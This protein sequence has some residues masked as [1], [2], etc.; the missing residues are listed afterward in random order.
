MS[1][2]IWKDL[3]QPYH[4]ACD[5]FATKIKNLAAEYKSC[6][7]YSPIESVYCRI[8]SPES[9]LAKAKRKGV[10]LTQ[11]EEKIEDIAGIRIICKFAD[12]IKTVVDLMRMRT[13]FDFEILAERDYIKNVKS[14]GYRSY[15]IIGKYSIFTTSGKKDVNIEVQARTMAMDFW[16]KTENSLNYKYGKNGK[17]LPES[18]KERLWQCAQVAHMLDCEMNSIRGEVL[19][20]QQIKHEKSQIVSEIQKNMNAISTIADLDEFINQNEKL[21]KLCEDGNY[22]KLNK[23]NQ[24]LKQIAVWEEK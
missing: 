19:E 3:L 13:G 2:I 11:I 21:I 23:L 9:I 14:S 10:P 5:E 17:N 1:T 12:D 18:L 6:G 7:Q 22:E 16:A 20:A 24:Q 4:Q 15:H 8:K